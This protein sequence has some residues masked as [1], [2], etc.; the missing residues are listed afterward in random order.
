MQASV[1]YHDSLHVPLWTFTSLFL[2]THLLFTF[3][4]HFSTCGSEQG[5]SLLYNPKHFFPGLWQALNH[6]ALHSDY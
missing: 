5:L 1:I 4:P 3:K 6:K 2:A